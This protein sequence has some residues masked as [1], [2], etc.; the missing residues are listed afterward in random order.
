MGIVDWVIQKFSDPTI[1]VGGRIFRQHT[2]EF[3][4]EL[5]Y[6]YTTIEKLL[7]DERVYGIVALIASLVSKAYVG[8]ELHPIDKYTDSELDEKERKALAEAEKV[9]RSDRLNFKQL[10]FDIAWELASHGDAYEVIVKDGTGIQKLVSQPLNATRSLANREQ[11][12]K[13]PDNLQIIEENIIAVKRNMNDRQPVVYNEDQYI[14]FSFKN[15]GVWRKDIEGV[16]TYGIYSKPPIATL[17]RLV[18]WKKKT[19]EN[20]ILWK[21]KLLPRI[22]HKLKMP[23]IVPS[24]YTGTPEEKISKAKTDADKLT[25]SFM[26]ATKP[27]RPDD[28]M[29]TSDAVDTSILE[30]KSANYQKPNET[31]SQINTLINTPQGIPSGLLG[32]EA[33]ASMGIELA[34]VFAGIRIDYIAKKIADGLT[35]VMKSHVRIAATSA[36]DEVI[37]RLYVHVDPALSVEKYEKIK[38]ALS[39]SATQVF[40]KGEVRAAAGY[41]RLPQL[42]KEA[43]PEVDPARVKQSLDDLT[44]DV[45][46]E[47]PGN[48][49]NNKSPQGDRN[50]ME[51]QR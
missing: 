3:F 45:K 37:D 44:S 30:A 22:L 6:D 35:E 4:G 49:A 7:E 21:N 39:M 47:K 38:T 24:K 25:N 13:M 31:I 1:P 17:Q 19:I 20:D 32:G 11:V 5:K 14:H 16:D 29:I 10:F 28:D 8:P 51:D 34:G 27:I 36:G 9:A 2:E 15:H 18:N 43:F 50:T 23:S 46:K 41:A 26:E 40:T 33:G 12:L 42:P 48:Q